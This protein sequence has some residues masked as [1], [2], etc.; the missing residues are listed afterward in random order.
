M[1][2]NHYASVLFL[3]V[4]IHADGQINNDILGTNLFAYCSNNPVMLCDSDGHIAFLTAC[5]IV[6]A[7]TL[8]IDWF[9][10]AA[11]ERANT[12]LNDPSLYNIAN[13]ATAG[14][15]DTVK[16]AVAPEKPL[17]AEHWIDSAATASL[18][19]GAASKIPVKSGKSAIPS[20]VGKPASRGSTAKRQPSNLTE[21]LAL[22]QVKSN[23][24]GSPIPITM[25]D[26]R[27]PASEG[28][29]KMQQI[30]P[31]SQGN[32]NIH[33]LYNESLKIYDDFKLN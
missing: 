5:F 3:P 21:Q 27:W 12:M 15:V 26:S 30:V 20:N 2:L 9:S 22:E 18:I 24:Q 1:P 17:S 14:L 29:V 31:T 8:A 13:W 7:V 23:P 32:I 10:G 16:G 19:V 25:A 11:Q 28:W 4:A 6:G 33:Y